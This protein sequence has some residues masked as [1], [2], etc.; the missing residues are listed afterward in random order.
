MPSGGKS[1]GLGQ[2]NTSFL[3]ARQQRQIHAA[4]SSVRTD[5]IKKLLLAY[6]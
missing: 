1:S 5:I 6:F 2:I 4:R 3:A